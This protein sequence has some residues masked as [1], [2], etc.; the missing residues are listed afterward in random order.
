[1]K[2]F[3][4]GVKMKK[5][6]SLMLVLVFILSLSTSVAGA[7]LVACVGDSDTYGAGLPDRA[8]NCYPAQL[9]RLLKQFDNYWETRNFGVNGACV[10]KKGW[11]PYVALN[12]FNNALACGPDVVVINLGWNDSVANNWI[13]KDDFIIDFLLL[14][15]AFAELPSQPKMYVCHPIPESFS[16]LHSSRVIRD[17]VIPLINQL[18]I[19]RD[20][21][22]IDLYTP[23]EESRH[24]FQPDGIHLNVEGTRLIAEIVSAFITGVR[25]NPDLN[26]DG[27][28][29]SEDMCILVEHWH[30][31]EPSCDIVPL[32]FGDKIV[33][34]QDLVAFAEHLFTYPGAVAY[35]KLD[36]K[37][38][39]IA[40][41]SIGICDGILNGVPTWQPTGGAVDGA[42]AFDSIDDYIET[43]FI[44]NPSVGNFSIFSWIKGSVP[45]QVI[46]SQQGTVNWLKADAQGNLMTE[47]KGNGRS[48][49]PL[50]SQ[51]VITNGEWHRIGFVWDGSNRTLY[52]DDI[53][54]AQDT[55]D[56]LQGSDS[57]LYIGTGNFMQPG[58]YWSGL[59]DDVRIYNRVVRP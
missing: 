18:P 15:D 24:L 40:Y 36:E 21:Q 42:L 48:A 9:E 49:K 46:L 34:V 30:T 57:G 22:V 26:G 54:V 41:D 38:G 19:Y 2:P 51:T 5:T 14:I 13:Y 37:E 45:G 8:Y 55:Q 39:D 7:K 27:I 25:A 23:L 53:A 35:W 44:L 12:A 11:N 16:S 50:L 59:I 17:E 58:T 1:M 10:L 31:N 20:V 3:L 29:N 4:K 52:V 47:L 6:I 43:N 32:P 56:S 33:D 28:V